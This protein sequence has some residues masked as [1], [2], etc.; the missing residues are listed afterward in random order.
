MILRPI[1]KSD[2]KM[3]FNIL[4]ERTPEQSIS[5]KEMPTWDEHVAFIESDPY[6]FWYAIENEN[7]P[8]GSVYITPA[9]EVGIFLFKAVQGEGYAGEALSVVMKMHPGKVLA[10]INPANHASKRFFQRMGF[11]QIQETWESPEDLNTGLSRWA[12]DE[13]NS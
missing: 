3:L 12:E 8:V 6:L 11:R 1:E 9:R 4:Q 2:Y 13:D 5:H 10:N 7:G